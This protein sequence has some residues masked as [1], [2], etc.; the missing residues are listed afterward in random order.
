MVWYF[1][2]GFYQRKNELDFT[3]KK[4][5]KYTVA[6]H[7]NPNKMTFYKSNLSDKW[8]LEV[9]NL[10]S[11]KDNH[12]VPCTYEDYLLATNGEVPNRWILTQSRM[13]F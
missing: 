6:F 11:E 9:E 12:I 2:E 4:F 1:I 8:W 3:G 5:T 10:T 13:G 7:D